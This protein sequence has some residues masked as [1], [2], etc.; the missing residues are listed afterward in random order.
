MVLREV[1]SMMGMMNYGNWGGDWNNM[2]SY[3]QKMMQNY[4]G[5]LAPFGSLFGLMH[6]ISW[7]LVMALL[8]TLIRYFWNKTK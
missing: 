8:V 2:P 1:I 6:L 7:V 3:M 5:G 4:Y